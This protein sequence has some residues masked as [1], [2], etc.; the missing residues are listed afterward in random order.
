VNRAEGMVL[1][2]SHNGKKHWQK[3]EI[4]YLCLSSLG[5]VITLRSCIAFL[6]LSL[7]SLLFLCFAI[8]W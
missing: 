5:L 6:L 3:S 7:K 2:K 4:N 8:V 1:V